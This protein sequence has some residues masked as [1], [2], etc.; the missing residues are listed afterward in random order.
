MDKWSLSERP[1]FLRLHAFK[2]LKPGN[3]LKAGNTLSQRIVRTSKSEATLQLDLHAMADGQQAGLCHFSKD[4][5]TLGITQ[6]GDVRTLTFAHA[7]KITA[8]P[9][10]SGESIWLRSTWDFSGQSQFSYS[11]DGKQ[12]TDFGSPV[13]LSWSYYRGD[14]I[15]IY[16]YNDKGEAGYVDVAAFSCRDAGQTKP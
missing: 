8:G 2:P 7:G 5:S 16:C 1:G 4:Y 13:P 14:R 3:L 15:G 12:Y 9:T 6:A 10:I 11:L